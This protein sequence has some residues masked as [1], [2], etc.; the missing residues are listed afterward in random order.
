MSKLNYIEACG[1]YYIMKLAFDL[2]YTNRVF[3]RSASLEDHVRPLASL[4]SR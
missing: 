3:K 1:L 4:S 2:Y